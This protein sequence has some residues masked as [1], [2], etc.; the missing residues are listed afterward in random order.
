MQGTKVHSNIVIYH[1]TSFIVLK[2]LFW[3]EGKYIKNIGI[4]LPPKFHIPLSD[5][6]FSNDLYFFHFN[7]YSE[8][9][10][11]VLKEHPNVVRPSLV[12]KNL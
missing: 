1:H 8:M 12:I 10:L 6:Q 3:E 9:Y 5:F 7:S 2:M 4:Y 11:Q